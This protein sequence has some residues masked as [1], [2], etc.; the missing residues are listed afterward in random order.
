ML[1]HGRY[2]FFREKEQSNQKWS[3][4]VMFCL[5]TG[6]CC[7][8]TGSGSARGVAAGTHPGVRTRT[9]TRAGICAETDSRTD[10]ITRSNDSQWCQYAAVIIS[11][12]SPV[13]P[14]SRLIDNDNDVSLVSFSV[15][16]W[17]GW[18]GN[19]AHS[20]YNVKYVFFVQISHGLTLL[21]PCFFCDTMDTRLHGTHFRLRPTLPCRQMEKAF[22]LQAR[23]CNSLVLVSAEC[24]LNCV[25]CTLSARH[26]R[27]HYLRVQDWLSRRR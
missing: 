24:H 5:K 12:S 4:S 23:Y 27:S 13:Y 20:V 25:C 21:R 19:K 8:R 18:R 22:E 10:E 3:I 7:S 26:W 16:N 17:Y 6:S 1:F 14:K 15:H 9:T 2:L 11:G